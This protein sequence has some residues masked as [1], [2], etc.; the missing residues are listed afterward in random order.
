MK[1][2]TKPINTIAYGR[3]SEIFDFADGKVLK[4]YSKKI[5]KEKVKREFE[6]TQKVYKTLKNIVPKAYELKNFS[7]RHGIVFEKIVGES[8]MSIFQKNPLEFFNSANIVSAVAKKINSY[9]ITNIPTQFKSFSGLIL[10]SNRVTDAEKKLLIDL[11]QKSKVKK[12]CH[13][14]LHH[15]NIMKTSTGEIVVLDWMDAFIG[16]PALDVTLTA[17]NAMVSDAPSHV[18]FIYRKLYEVLKKIICLDTRYSKLFPEFT[19]KNIEE[20]MVLAAGIHLV[21]KEGDFSGHRKYFDRV[22]K[23][24]KK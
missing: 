11:L 1:I 23:K 20:M 22:L 7:N 19:P 2:N 14:D 9:A 4:L 13:G 17:V 3:E 12:L 21:R 18:P 6:I 5:S 8:Y 16:D 24:L 15:G 10:G